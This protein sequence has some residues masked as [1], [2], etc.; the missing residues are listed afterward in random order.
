MIEPQSWHIGPNNIVSGHG[1]KKRQSRK[2]PRSAENPKGRESK[3]ALPYIFVSTQ[4]V[5][6]SF[7]I[8]SVAAPS[9][10]RIAAR[11]P[12]GPPAAGGTSVAIPVF[13]P[14]PLPSVTIHGR[15]KRRRQRQQ[16]S[17]GG[18]TGSGSCSSKH[19]HGRIGIQVGERGFTDGGSPDIKRFAGP[20]VRS[21]YSFSFVSGVSSSQERRSRG[22]RSRLT[23]VLRFVGR[24]DI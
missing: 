16:Q 7:G 20:I 22:R 4:Y 14:A 10:R 8:T 3:V 2:T 17:H 24:A 15:T 19:P 23:P 18:G 12:R 13:I 11:T 21:A 1:K 5:C 6:N 9:V